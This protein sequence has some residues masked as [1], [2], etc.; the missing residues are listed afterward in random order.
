MLTHLK[1]QLNTAFCGRLLYF[2]NVGLLYAR[3][4]LL[5]VSFREDNAALATMAWRVSREVTCPF[6]EG[7]ED[8]RSLIQILT[9]VLAGRR[10]VGRL[11]VSIEEGEDT[12]EELVK[13]GRRFLYS[14]NLLL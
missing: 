3:M 1:T 5:C 11:H 14:L 9:L 13:G 7:S 4:A 10:M 6:F 12:V 8:F 2:I